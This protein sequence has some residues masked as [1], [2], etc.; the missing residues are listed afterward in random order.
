MKWVS[1]VSFL[2]WLTSCWGE[3]WDASSTPW[4]LD[5]V[6]LSRLLGNERGPGEASGVPSTHCSPLHAWPWW[7]QVGKP[8]LITD[9]D[10][11]RHHGCSEGVN[12][13]PEDTG[14]LKEVRFELSS[15]WIRVRI[16]DPRQKGGWEKRQKPESGNHVQGA[17]GRL[18]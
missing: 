10:S 1:A 6:L 4:P 13:K 12:R 11:N 3:A 9:R 8:G 7:S 2:C 16:P 14:F 18:V 15:K 5:A 17:T